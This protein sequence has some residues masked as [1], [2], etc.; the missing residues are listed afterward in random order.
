MDDELRQYL[1]AVVMLLSLNAGFLATL[2]WVSGDAVS[3]GFVVVPAV[4]L[5]VAFGGIVWMAASFVE[6]P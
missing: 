1:A 3:P 5:G 4:V 6:A 2:V